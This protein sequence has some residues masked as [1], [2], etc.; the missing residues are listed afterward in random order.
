MG[1][2]KYLAAGDAQP[3]TAEE[4]AEYRRIKPDLLQMMAEWRLIRSRAGC[5]IFRE[6]VDPTPPTE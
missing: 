3:V 5:P 6:V 2:P 4:L 1:E